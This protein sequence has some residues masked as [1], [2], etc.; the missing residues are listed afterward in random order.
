MM[1]EARSRIAHEL[2]VY[3]AIAR[4]ETTRAGAHFV[5]ITPI[6]RQHADLVAN[7][8]LHPSAAQYTLWLMR[9]CR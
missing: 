2:D 3:N 8:G 4:D 7:D 1:P 5:N 9:S 6:S